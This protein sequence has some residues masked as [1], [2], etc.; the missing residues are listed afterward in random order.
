MGESKKI[1]FDKIC[2]QTIK[3][4]VERLKKEVI[5]DFAERNGWNKF[6]RTERDKAIYNKFKNDLLFDIMSR[7][8]DSESVIENLQKE[9]QELNETAVKHEMIKKI[10]NGEQEDDTDY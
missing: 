5:A 9:I 10:L 4:C 7:L 1:S 3:M 2:D 8:Y 6:L